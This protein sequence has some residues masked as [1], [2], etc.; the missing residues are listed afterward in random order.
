MPPA[1][2]QEKTWDS[3][4]AVLLD[5]NACPLLLTPAAEA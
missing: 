5:P 4:E 3:P 1:G 2:V